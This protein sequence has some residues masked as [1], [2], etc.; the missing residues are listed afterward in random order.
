MTPKAF[1]A[2]ALIQADGAAF[3]GVEDSMGKPRESRARRA[4]GTQILH[5]LALHLLLVRLSQLG[6]LLSDQAGP[7]PYPPNCTMF[8]CAPLLVVRLEG[9]DHAGALP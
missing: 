2:L 9:R 8:P 4:T 7:A 1:A 6:E 3:A 5:L